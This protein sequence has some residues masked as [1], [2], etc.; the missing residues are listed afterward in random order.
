MN[1]TRGYGS[2]ILGVAIFSAS[3]PATRIA[4][5]GFTPLF[6]TAARAVLAATIGLFLLLALRQKRP[7]RHDLVALAI[8]AA[9]G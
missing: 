7:A 5:A 2:G 3:L 9:G 1:T 8:V 4:E 6:L